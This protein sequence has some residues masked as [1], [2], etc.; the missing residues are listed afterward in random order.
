MT[1]QT[2][3][4]LSPSFAARVILTG[5]DNQRCAQ[6]ELQLGFRRDVEFVSLGHH[7][8]C[9][10]SATTDTCA[11]RSTFATAGDCTNCSPD[12]GANARP[13][14]GLCATPISFFGIFGSL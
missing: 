14:R 3:N 13:L 7:L 1:S 8:N 4:L 12:A 10:C 9:S 2:P 6:R 5:S 11:D